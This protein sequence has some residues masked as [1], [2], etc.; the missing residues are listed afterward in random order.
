M[1]FKVRY[2][3]VSLTIPFHSM[4]LVFKCS[5]ISICCFIMYYN[6]L[7]CLKSLTET[8]LYFDNIT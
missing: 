5:L 2:V 1:E 4:K 6:I 3:C 7:L 8:K